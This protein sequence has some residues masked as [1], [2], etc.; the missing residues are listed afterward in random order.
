M[1]SLSFSA[2]VASH[3]HPAR[4]ALA[5]AS[6]GW[7]DADLPMLMASGSSLLGE[8][9]YTG[10][11]R[12][13]CVIANTTLAELLDGAASYVDSTEARAPP[14]ADQQKVIWEKTS[15]EVLA[16]F[17]DPPV[18]MAAVD[19]RWGRN[20]WRP[21]VR[22]AVEESSGKFRVIDSGLSGSHNS[23]TSAS[24]RIHTCSNLSS[25]AI[26]RVAALET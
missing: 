7:P 1:A 17:M 24:E 25:L 9:A 4:V 2:R 3:A 20:L 19:V 11:S 14:C 6:L 16:K 21:V 10:I 26:A 15:H 12:P 13:G 8:M 22:F 5:M 18:S 23:C